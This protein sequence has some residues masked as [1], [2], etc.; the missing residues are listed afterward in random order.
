MLGFGFLSLPTWFVHIAS[1]IEWAIAVVLV[2][3]LGQRL[4]QV[5]LQRLPWAMIPYMLSGVCA[6]WYHVTYD[7]Q[8]WLSDAQSY[9]TFLGSTAFGVWAFF[10]LR[11]LQ[12]FRIS[13]LSAR[14]GQPSKR[15]GGVSDHV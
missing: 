15:E 7:T 12:T 8:Q 10:F 1:L 13:S 6:I 9:L 3:Q 4:N 11:S 5:W 2:Y 14:S